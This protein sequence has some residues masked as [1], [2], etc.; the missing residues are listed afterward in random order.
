MVFRTDHPG[1]PMPLLTGTQVQY[2][3]NLPVDIE[4]GDGFDKTVAVATE[5]ADHLV[6]T[7]GGVFGAGLTMVFGG[8]EVVEVDAMEGDDTVDVLSTPAGVGV[9][10]IAGLGSDV[11]DVAGDVVPRRRGR[12][13]CRRPDRVHQAPAP[14]L[15]P[16][17]SARRG[18]RR[19][20]GAPPCGWRSCSRA[21][22]TSR[23]FALAPL[24][25]ESQ[26]V[27]LLLVFD[28]SNT[29][30]QSA[31]LTSTA[32]TGLGMA[33]ALTFG[34]PPRTGSRPRSA[35]ASPSATPSRSSACCWG[36]ATTSCG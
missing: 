3:V 23:C 20:A 29:V 8:V 4:G 19:R 10:V 15:D 6:V 13:R 17:R 18:R 28:D 12:R 5:F 33:G 22:P 27:D 35:P 16:R 26:Q 25:P 7:N 24:P 31:T 32:L 21:R 2:T 34:L 9:R 11:V 36:R 14:A 30:G 1:V